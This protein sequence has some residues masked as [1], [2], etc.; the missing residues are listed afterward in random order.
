MAIHFRQGDVLAAKSEKSPDSDTLSGS[1]SRATATRIIAQ[2]IFNRH[3]LDRTYSQIINNLPTTGSEPDRRLIQ[4]LAYGTVRWWTTLESITSNLLEQPLKRKNQDLAALIA[5]GLYQLIHTDIP[6]HAAVSET[7]GA[8]P[9]I[10]KQW[11]RGLVNAVLRRFI[12]ERSSLDKIERSLSVKTA[13]PEWLIT[14]LNQA[15]PQYWRAIIDANNCRPLLTLRVNTQKTS[16]EEYLCTLSSSSIQA[17]AITDCPS[18]IQLVSRHPVT[19]LPGFIEGVVS[20][21]DC[22][23]QLA[24]LALSARP[25]MRVLDACAAPGG[26]T[27]H[28]LE[29]CPELDEL[30]ALDIDPKRAGRIDENLKRLGLDA[31]V[32]IGDGIDTD[33]WWDGRLFDRILIDAPCSGTGVIAKHPDIRHLRRPSDISQLAAKQRLLLNALWP[34][35]TENGY[36]LYTTCSVLPQENTLQI[37][38]FLNEHPDATHRLPNTDLQSGDRSIGLVQPYGY[39]R[40][41]GVHHGDGFFYAGLAKK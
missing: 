14:A 22:S 25:G 36:L 13:H 17:V 9:L 40:L 26:K 28:L 41:Q 20:V 31:K 18:A 1:D 3:S 30:V 10:G 12:K 11:A 4:E 29:L 15:W 2:V 34:L 39:Q 24:S 23:A 6:H 7:V 27:T 33:K 8:A 37:E 32:V 38:S 35:L 16:R 21:Q 19:S 5:L